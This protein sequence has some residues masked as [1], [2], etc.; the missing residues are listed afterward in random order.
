MI[1]ALIVLNSTLF[2][3]KSKNSKITA[4]KRVWGTYHFFPPAL[5]PDPEVCKVNG[6]L[7]QNHE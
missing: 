2:A 1:V 3:N 4:G 7:H 5:A 6:R